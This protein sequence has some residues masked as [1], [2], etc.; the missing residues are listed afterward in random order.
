M[1]SEPTLPAKGLTRA[2]LT[3]WGLALV[4]TGSE[5]LDLDMVR[6]GKQALAEA[7]MLVRDWPPPS[8][9]KPL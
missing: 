6:Q 8:L 1:T 9:R 3:A 5:H 7:E 2:G 4:K